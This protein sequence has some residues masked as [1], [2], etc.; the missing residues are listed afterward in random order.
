M[1]R[2]SCYGG[3]GC[4]S[5]CTCPS[6]QQCTEKWLDEYQCS[7]SNSQR[8]YQKADCSTEWRAFATCLYGCSTNGKCNDQS[9]SS[10]CSCSSGLSCSSNC[11]LTNNG[12][13]SVASH[14]CC[15]KEGYSCVTGDVCCNDKSCSDGVCGG[16]T[17]KVGSI[18]GRVTDAVNGNPLSNVQ[19]YINVYHNAMTDSTGSYKISDLEP[20]TY[21]LLAQHL[22]G[23]YQPI[24]S[25]AVVK[26]GAETIANFQLS[27]N[28]CNSI[29]SLPPYGT[30]GT[31]RTNPPECSNDE[32]ST[33]IGSGSGCRDL[34][35]ERCCCRKQISSTGYTIGQT[36]TTTLNIP[37]TQSLWLVIGS[38]IQ[39]SIK[40]D[41]NPITVSYVPTKAGTITIV[42]FIFE[43]AFKVLI[44][45]ISVK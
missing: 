1:S 33:G 6:G 32:T 45:K 39:G 15:V 19:V 11:L 37:S 41:D 28:D 21:T 40:V 31:C 43:P 7:E 12:G 27:P 42:T 17:I 38:P 34:P 5:D 8:K 3:A 26:A 9:S 29:C 4:G 24:S 35:I 13:C 22:S 14:D 36:W 25:S 20:N 44:D 16:G 18:S 23:K 2:S 30:S 10:S